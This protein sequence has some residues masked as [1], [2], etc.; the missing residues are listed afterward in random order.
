MVPGILGKKLGMTQIFVEGG[1]RLPV[2]ILEVGPCQV[3]AVKTQERDGYHAVQLGFELTK[4][5][6]LKKPQR[7]YIKAKGLKAMKFSKE[8]RCP[9][10]PGVQ[11]GDRV[12]V[13]DFQVGD[14]LD[15]QG[16]TKGK[17]F[18]G[19]VKRCGWSGGEQT[20]GS[21][22]HRVPGSIGAS[23]SPSRVF[24][25][26]GMPG[27]MGNKRNT[28]QNLE[29][30]DIDTENGTL[31]VKGSVPGSNGMFLI[32]RLAEKLPQ[33]PRPERIVEEETPEEE[34]TGEEAAMEDKAVSDA[35]KETGEPEGTTDEEKRE[36]GDQQEEAE[37]EVE[38]PNGDKQSAVKEEESQASASATEEDNDKTEKGK[39]DE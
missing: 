31:A 1:R 32:A 16:I 21:K 26:H 39:A 35:K 7:V 37:A 8:I 28:V 14:F 6:R 17:G 20:H 9:E 19:G 24:K 4:E 25:G 38:S 33:K 29:V 15:V 22:T 18:Q 11:V 23:A 36:S 30:V 27:Q 13:E 2:T 34:V 3:Q 12:T 10:D 5:K